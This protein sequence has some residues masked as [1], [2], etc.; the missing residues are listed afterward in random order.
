M[1]DCGKVLV[2]GRSIRV[3]V[4]SP[5]GF[6]IRSFFSQACE[7]ARAVARGERIAGVTCSGPLGVDPADR[8]KLCTKRKVIIVVSPNRTAAGPTGC[9]PVRH[10]G[11]EY[12]VVKARVLC[13]YARGTAL[14]MLRR[15]DPYIYE[16]EFPGQARRWSCHILGRGATERGHCYKQVEKRWLMYFPAPK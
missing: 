16:F 6:S 12:K 9:T 1:Q 4:Q 7:E 8:Y 15:Q 5:G 14:R 3:Y 11:H 10:N 13:T 2:K